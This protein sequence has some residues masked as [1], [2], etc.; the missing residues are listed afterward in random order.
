MGRARELC[1][2]AR[3]RWIA[4]ALVVILLAGLQTGTGGRYS[5]ADAVR[6]QPC[7]GLLPR[8]ELSAMSGWNEV[9]SQHLAHTPELHRLTCTLLRESVAGEEEWLSLSVTSRPEDMD[10][11]LLGAVSWAPSTRWATLPQALPGLLFEESRTTSW[12]VLMP[13]CAAPDRGLLVSLETQRARGHDEEMLRA[14]VSAANA[15]SVLLGCGEPSLPFPEDPIRRHDDG[16]P[17]ALL[18]PD[19]ACTAFLPEL[20]PEAPDGGWRIHEAAP[21]HGPFGVCA[22]PFGPGDDTLVVHA[23]YNSRAESE[24]VM[25]NWPGWIDEEQPDGPHALLSERWQPRADDMQAN[26]FT[27]CDGQFA[28][29]QARADAQGALTLTREQ[30]RAIVTAF[31]IDQAGRRGCE[32]PVLP[33]LRSRSSS[34]ASSTGRG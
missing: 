23:S 8:A 14:A 31:A 15:A 12:I 26:A 1:R 13:P 34:T 7:A 25:R 11:A 4:I 20:P 18:A 30:L 16:V 21:D 29:F 3:E 6:L 22:V 17:A 32:P 28:H 2:W 5:A 24:A 33:P 10:V 19:S 27:T 9:R